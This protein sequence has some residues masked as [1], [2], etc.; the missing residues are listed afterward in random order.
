MS[1]RSAL[2]SIV[3]AVIL[4]VSPAVHACTT[5]SSRGLFGR[6]YDWNIGYG[7]VTVN[8]RGMS[9][10]SASEESPAKWISRYGSL[11]FN[12]Y[13]RDNPTGGMNEAGLVVE[14]MWLS[15][16]R[17]PAPDTRPALG[18]LEWI[19]YQ[20]DNASTV[21]EAIVNANRVRI[22]PSAAP[23]HF[24]LADAKGNRA[25]LEF[26]DGKVVVHRGAAAL[27][28]DPYT[29]AVAALKAGTDDRFSRA[30]HGL[31]EAVTLDAAFALLDRVAQ[32]HTQWSIVYDMPNRRVTWR[33]KANREA[34]SVAL[35]SLDFS[36]TTPVQVVDI[37]AGKGNVSSQFRDYSTTQNLALVR[38][39]VRA[40]EFLHDRTDEDIA[41]AAK[42]PETSSC[43]LAR[44]Q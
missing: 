9:K 15:G 43:V 11:T 33:T 12:Q 14:L 37:D 10:S 42:W 28:N 39:S 32:P 22:S 40:T 31:D 2:A 24:L 6:N 5:F 35:G 20:L 16:T 29:E 41:K 26:L 17:Y 38:R 21:A 34:R 27:A 30:I 7:M 3:I 4:A 23:L 19:Q 13:G 1:R 8:K 25:A 44:A 36:C 18:G